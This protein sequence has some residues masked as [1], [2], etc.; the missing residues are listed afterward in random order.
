V[1][2]FAPGSVPDVLKITLTASAAISGQVTCTGRPIAG[3]SVELVQ[4]TPNFLEGVVENHGNGLY[5]GSGPVVRTDAQGRFRVA[6][7]FPH[8]TYYARAV[9]DGYAEA[10]VGPLKVGASEV[11]VE[12]GEGGTVSGVVRLPRG[13]PASEVELEF[14]REELGIRIGAESPGSVR[15][16]RTKVDG[17]YAMPH[18]AVGAWLVRVRPSGTMISDLGWS[19]ERAADESAPHV[20]TVVDKATTQFDVALSV[21]ELCVLEGRISVGDRIRQGYGELML[22]GPLALRLGFCG[23][24]PSGR[25]RLAVRP[26]GTHRLVLNA[27]P[28]HHQYKTITDLVELVPGTNTWERDLPLDRWVGEGVRLD[29]H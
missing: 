28:G 4:R 20:V 24:D 16:T 3:A 21:D 9:C 15:R 18:L 22:E 1:G 19:K 8:L 10:L 2:S 5:Y 26:S 29:P 27:G 25:F 6:N 7:D 14:Y 17:S 11:H 23:I 12:L 13:L